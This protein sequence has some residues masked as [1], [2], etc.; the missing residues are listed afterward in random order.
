MFRPTTSRQRIARGEMVQMYPRMMN[1]K[2]TSSPISMAWQFGA[3]AWLMSA[4]CCRCCRRRPADSKES[5]DEGASCLGSMTGGRAAPTGHFAYA[6][7]EPLACHSCALPP[8]DAGNNTK[9]FLFRLNWPP[10]GEDGESRT[11]TGCEISLY[12]ALRGDRRFLAHGQRRAM[13]STCLIRDR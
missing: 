1:M 11:T 2:K 10:T 6:L 13:R 12:Y 9:L 4:R 5:E 3:H 8:S 7:G